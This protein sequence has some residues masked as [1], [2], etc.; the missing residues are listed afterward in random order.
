MAKEYGKKTFVGNVIKG[1]K[2]A[3][4]KE[5]GDFISITTGQDFVLKKGMS[6]NLQFPKDRVAQLERDLAYAENNGK[7]TDKIEELLLSAKDTMEK[8]KV[9]FIIT[10]QEVKEI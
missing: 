10:H 6:L 8:G 5:Y 2:S 9:R 3:S 1:G 7:P 4:G